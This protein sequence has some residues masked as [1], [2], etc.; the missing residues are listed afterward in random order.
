MGNFIMLRSNKF[1]LK[2]MCLKAVAVSTVLGVLLA[3]GAQAVT[4]GEIK[5]TKT[6]I[7]RTPPFD[8]T[9]ANIKI[10]AETKQLE[11]SMSVTGVAGS[12]KPKEKD[13]VRSAQMA[14]YVWTIGV[15][16]SVV[17]FEKDAGTLALAISAH[18]DFDDNLSGDGKGA[19]DVNG[20]ENAKGGIWHAHWVVLTRD[21][22][23]G[24]NALKAV[25]IAKG[26]TPAVPK[27]WSG[28]PILMSNVD[29]EPKFSLTNVSVQVP[30]PDV[31]VFKGA[32]YDGMTAVFRV[33]E[34]PTRPY[35]CVSRVIDTVSD[36]LNFPGTIE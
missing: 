7:R 4:A 22:S 3:M 9:K 29:A 27:A 14:A 16:P 5:T 28:L 18:P 19:K 32:A 11:F 30:V 17:G 1:D 36:N 8:I 23:C 12:S 34:Q 21:N 33:K 31:G 10:N 26:S 25:D 35:F 6:V 15:N 20:I 24:N 2:S 13:K